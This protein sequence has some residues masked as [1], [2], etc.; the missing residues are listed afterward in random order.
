MLADGCFMMKIPKHRRR[1][2]FA[3]LGAIALGVFAGGLVSSVTI[4]SDAS[5]TT[6]DWLGWVILT[7]GRLQATPGCDRHCESFD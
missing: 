4:S 6:T 1:I 3:R 5:A 2:T 7:D